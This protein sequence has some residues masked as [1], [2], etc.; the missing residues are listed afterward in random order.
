M[1]YQDVTTTKQ[2]EKYVK[3]LFGV[4][5]K[6]YDL[7]NDILSGGL[8]RYWKRYAAKKSGIK[9]GSTV[10]DLCSGTQDI[11][12]LLAKKVTVL[13]Q[14]VALDFSQEMLS[15]GNLKAEKKRVAKQIKP[16]VGDAAAIDFPDN[17]FDAATIG[18]GLR[19][20]MDIDKVLK[21]MLRVIKPGGK[22]VIL[23]FSHPP[24]KTFRKL[25]DLY[26]FKVL[27][28]IGKT[29]S[30]IDDGYN[31]LPD[32][33]RKFPKQVELV[34]RM[35]KAGFKNVAYKNLTGG[36]VAVHVGEKLT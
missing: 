14:V 21:E 3:K 15:L 20:V 34:N 2:K 13:G 32:S 12:I 22:A 9:K 31:Y 35:K 17:S 10:I 26:S 30:K 29:V 23:E 4:A 33:I 16:F 8:H 36:V 19:N 5:A 28:K 25:Y 11:A 1:Q 7:L 24:N 6:K 27:P 18:F